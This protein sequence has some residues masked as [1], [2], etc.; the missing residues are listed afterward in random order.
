MP[1]SPKIGFKTFVWSTWSS[2][3]ASLARGDLAGEAPAIGMRT[4]WRT[5][6]SMPLAAVAISSV[7]DG[8]DEEDSG[9]VDRQDVAA[10]GRAAPRAGARA[11]GAPMTRE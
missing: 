8:V 11:R 2:I 5:S 1:L 3:T 9:R 4:P 10:P 7:P 6:S